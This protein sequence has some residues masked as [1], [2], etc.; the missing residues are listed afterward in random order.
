MGGLKHKF[1]LE[2]NLTSPEARHPNYKNGLEAKILKKESIFYAEFSKEHPDIIVVEY[3]PTITTQ[4][5][6]YKK[7]KHLNGNIKRRIFL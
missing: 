7:V 2:L 6:I 3:D 1:G 4:D 5:T